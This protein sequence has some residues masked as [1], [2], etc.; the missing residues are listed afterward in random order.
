MGKRSLVQKRLQKLVNRNKFYLYKKNRKP[1]CYDC[2]L[3]DK[4][5]H[6]FVYSEEKEKIRTYVKCVLC[7]SIIYDGTESLSRN[8]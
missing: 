8:Y 5:R 1:N 6:I 3:S 4:F 2:H 7:N